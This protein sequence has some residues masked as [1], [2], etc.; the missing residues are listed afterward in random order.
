MAEGLARKLAPKGVSIYSAGSKPSRI[1]PFAVQALSEVG[2]DASQQYSKS[3]EDIPKGAVDTVITLCAEEVCPV[4]LHA[5]E[6][7]HWPLPDPAGVE[8]SEEE[9]LQSFRRVRDEIESRLK[10]FFQSRS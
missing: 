7:L 4:Y 5:K 2:I 9:K 3:A 10:A 1:N 8:G 6:R